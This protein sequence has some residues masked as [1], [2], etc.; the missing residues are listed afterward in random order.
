VYN[1]NYYQNDYQNM[2]DNASNIAVV[3]YVYEQGEA[4]DDFIRGYVLRTNTSEVEFY[5]RWIGR[6]VPFLYPA[7]NNNESFDVVSNLNCQFSNDAQLQF[8]F[9]R[10]RKVIDRIPDRNE[11][12][13]L[14]ALSFKDEGVVRMKRAQVAGEAVTVDDFASLFD[15]AMEHY[16]TV[17][18]RYLAV[19]LPV[20][21]RTDTEK[22]SFPRSYLFTYPD[23]RSAFTPHEPRLFFYPYT[24][25]GW[26]AYLLSRN[27]LEAFYPARNAEHILSWLAYHKVLT[28]GYFHG[29]ASFRTPISLPLLQQL[30]RHLTA[31]QEKETDLNVLHLQLGVLA[32]AAGEQDVAVAQLK[33]L[34]ASKFVSLFQG[35]AD[36]NAESFFLLG[37]AVKVLTEYNHWDEAYSLLK[38]FKNPIN[39]SSLYAFAA[40]E[41]LQQNPG[42]LP[43]TRL[44]DS[45]QVEITRIENLTTGQ[46]NRQ[47]IS[48]ALALQNPER[49]VEEAHRVIKNIF[50]KTLPTQKICRSFAYHDNL[51]EARAHV[52][53]NISDTDQITFLWNIVYGYNLA[54]GSVKPEWQGYSARYFPQH[55]RFINYIN[56]DN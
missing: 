6:S 7:V 43:A 54:Q 36:E 23:Y 50:N 33:K 12:A 39:R 30:E 38:F 15:A 32:Y 24:S 17:D 4:L 8:I 10:F 47:L 53:S 28:F 45:A 16:R 35:L 44:L 31:Q 9:S 49:N 48:Q 25:E 19:E 1:Q 55:N 18:P 40:V 22:R 56:E 5:Q 29:N 13:F 2:I 11:Q 41:L 20:S 52:V 46:P 51:Y 34:D 26:L 37:H 42:S 21:I 27:L 3:F 14:R